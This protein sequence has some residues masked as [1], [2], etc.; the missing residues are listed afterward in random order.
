MFVKARLKL[1]GWYLLIIMMVSLAFS[2]VIYRTSK[3]ELERFAEAQLTRFERRILIPDSPVEYRT[4]IHPTIDQELIDETKARILASLLV[5]NLGIMAMAGILGYYLSGKTLAPI[6]AMMDEQNRF[7]SDASHELKT[8]ITAIKTTIEVALRDKNLQIGE[9][10]QTLKDSLDEVNRLQ[11]LAEGLLELTHKNIVDSLVTADLK[12]VVKTAVKMIQ[13]LSVVKKIDIVTKFPT[14]FSRID[15]SSMVRALVAILDNAVKY[16]PT[17]STIMVNGS[18]K[19]QSII[20]K[21]SDY[22]VGIKQEDIP[23]VFDRLYRSDPARSTSGYGLGLSIAKQIVL[24]HK[25]QIKISSK[26][27]KGTNVVI[28]LPY[29]AK[30]QRKTKT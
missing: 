10:N 29:S 5:I 24:A 18:V 1:T 4:V 30:L 19:N 27:G 12:Q 6:Q 9:A 7:I 11:T 16:S 20:I 14:I 28:V 25:G 22:G 3:Y 13:P 17:K 21:I 2:G 15:E 26:I 23:L 8:P